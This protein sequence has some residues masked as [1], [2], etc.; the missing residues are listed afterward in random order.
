MGRRRNR[1]RKCGRLQRL[2]RLAETDRRPPLGPRP[3]PWPRTA[4]I[5]HLPL[6]PGHHDDEAAKQH[7]PQLPPPY[8]GSEPPAR[9][10]YASGR[11]GGRPP[12]PGRQDRVLRFAQRPRGWRAS[13]SAGRDHATLW[14]ELGMGRCHGGICAML[15]C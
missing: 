15:N 4:P 14:L 13:A 5:R 6:P 3:S 7:R 10:G 2:D 9:T 12:H 1:T 11:W 8:G